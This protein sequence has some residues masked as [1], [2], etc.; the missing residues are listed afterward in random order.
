M[1]AGR[2]LWS[3]LFVITQRPQH[4][5]PSTAAPT[6]HVPLILLVQALAFWHDARSTSFAANGISPPGDWQLKPSKS[7]RAVPALARTE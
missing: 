7:Q 4:S 6:Q 5:G 3:R 1:P 2:L